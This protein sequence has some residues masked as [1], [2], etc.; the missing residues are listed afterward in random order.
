MSCQRLPQRQMQTRQQKK[1]RL[2]PLRVDIDFLDFGG[3]FS[4]PVNS[5][6]AAYPLESFV[7]PLEKASA[8][9]PRSVRLALELGRF[10]VAPT[11]YFCTRVETLKHSKGQD[12]AICDCGMNGFSGF[13]TQSRFKRQNYPC[14]HIPSRDRASRRA[15]PFLG[16]VVGPLCTPADTLAA[17]LELADLSE[18]DLLA[19]ANCGAYG[20]THA[21]PMFLSHEPPMEIGVSESFDGPKILRR[22]TQLADSLLSQGGDTR[23]IQ[24]VLG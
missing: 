4:F 1:Q 24:E 17:N 2:T 10:V 8:Q 19:F 14:N 3:G 20:L 9:F 5:S 15:K 13:A 6:P 11:G 12:F 7:Q 23:L 16:D 18:G 22:S 21:M